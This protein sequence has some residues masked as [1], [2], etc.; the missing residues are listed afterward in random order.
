MARQGLALK[1]A[2]QQLRQKKDAAPMKLPVPKAA[3]SIP[4]AMRN[5]GLHPVEEGLLG[6]EARLQIA[7]E[8]ILQL[9]DATDRLRLT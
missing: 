3:E 1:S 6:D 5:V 7:V 4:A 9:G 8:A 2:T